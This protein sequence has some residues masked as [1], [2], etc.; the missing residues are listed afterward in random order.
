MYRPIVVYQAPQMKNCRNIITESFA[1]VLTMPLL[2]V[3]VCDA[4]S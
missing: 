1:R 2:P 4:E 3:E